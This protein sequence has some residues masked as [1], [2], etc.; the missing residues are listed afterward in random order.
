M[1]QDNKE[2][3]GLKNLIAP[4]VESRKEIRTTLNDYAYYII[5]FLVSLL[6]IFV[7]PLF[8][9]CLQGDIGLAFPKTMEA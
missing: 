7:P 3:F 6:V 1:E 2:K 8:A 4:S 5:I 9:G